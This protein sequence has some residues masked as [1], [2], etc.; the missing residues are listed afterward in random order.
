[1]RENEEAPDTLASDEDAGGIDGCVLELR[2]D[3]L[4]LGS[5]LVHVVQV[6]GLDLLQGDAEPVA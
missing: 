2:G 6:G 3:A 5:E 4:V 1:V